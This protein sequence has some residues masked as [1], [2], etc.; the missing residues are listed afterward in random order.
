MQAMVQLF[1][2]EKQKEKISLLNSF[3]D[4]S[5]F[6]NCFFKLDFALN[7]H[8]L[9][10]I[11]RTAFELRFFRKKNTVISRPRGLVFFQ[12][13]SQINFRFEIIFFLKKVKT[14]LL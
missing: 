5:T 14:G 2:N 13:H 4:T 12:I 9:R 6:F 3:E 8:L 10:V 1:L 11:S 7:G